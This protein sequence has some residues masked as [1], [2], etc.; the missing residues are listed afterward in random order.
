[1]R[2]DVIRKR[3]NDLEKG[4]HDSLKASK[5]RGKGLGSK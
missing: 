3:F 1:M 2:P 4:F 5:A